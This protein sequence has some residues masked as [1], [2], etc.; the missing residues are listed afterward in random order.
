VV[1]DEDPLNKSQKFILEMMKE[2]DTLTVKRGMSPVYYLNI[3]AMHREKN[4][5]KSFRLEALATAIPTLVKV[6]EMLEICDVAR[7]TKVKATTRR[8]TEGN[9]GTVIGR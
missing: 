4:G 1:A 2:N 6:C 9:P 7:K 8:M 5:G 3:L